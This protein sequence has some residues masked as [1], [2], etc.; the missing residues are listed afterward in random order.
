VA[1][2]G[3]N[4]GSTFT[5]HLPL[6]KGDASEREVETS[7]VAASGEGLR[8]LVVDDN[9]DSAKTMGWTLEALGHKYRLAFDG[10]SAIQA[11]ESYL[12]QLVLLDIGLPGMTGYEVCTALKTLPAL[13]DT[14]FVAQTGWGQPEDKEKARLAGFNHHL[15]KPVDIRE[16]QKIID[17][18]RAGAAAGTSQN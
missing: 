18:Y 9:Q 4:L 8:V 3:K 10:Q 14:L 5:V 15:V 2:E 6:Y 17:G 16:L 7:I 13:R 11:G 1:S 12:P